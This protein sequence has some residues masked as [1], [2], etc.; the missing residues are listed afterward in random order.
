MANIVSFTTYGR[1]IHESA[2]RAAFTLLDQS[3]PPD[4]VICWCQG[5]PP[6]LLKGMA[7]LEVREVSEEYGS[8]NK[9]FWAMQEFPEDN[10]II[11]DDDCYYPYNWFGILLA[12]HKKDT[13]KIVLGRCSRIKTINA[14][15]KR[16]YGY[17]ISSRNPERAAEPFPSTANC[18]PIHGGGALY[19]P[20]S[21]HLDTFDPKLF[22]SIAPNNDDIWLWAGAL[23]QNDDPY[24][25]PTPEILKGSRIGE[26]D[27][28]GQNLA[29]GQ[30]LYVKNIRGGRSVQVME[31]LITAYP[32]LLDC[33]KSTGI[34][35]EAKK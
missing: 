27:P 4:K 26:Q 19:P 7:G 23:L 2:A 17:F 21:L 8:H 29:G 15:Y 11:A 3:V 32:Q 16:E 10:I 34:K 22:Q 6:K 12:M 5:T 14:L 25:L 28:C 20:N 1:R 33:L 13:S 30:A 9:W 24:T 18:F 31:D 35:M